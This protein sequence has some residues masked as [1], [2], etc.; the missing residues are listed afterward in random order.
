MISVEARHEY[1]SIREWDGYEQPQY[2]RLF[3][4]TEEEREFKGGRFER[5]GFG[6]APSK[7][8]QIILPADSKILNIEEIIGWIDRNT[9]GIW[10]FEIYTAIGPDFVW[11]FGFVE[12]K[13]AMAFKLCW[14]HLRDEVDHIFMHVMGEIRSTLGG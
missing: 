11:V 7:E 14:Y 6:R 2:S 4:I 3:K 5:K 8:L 10:N 12:P 13:D 9:T 1:V